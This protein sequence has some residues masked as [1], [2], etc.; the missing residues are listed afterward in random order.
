MSAPPPP[1][2]PPAAP[3]FSDDENLRAAQA[4][5]ER[6]LMRQD[7]TTSEVEALREV[8]Y[9]LRERNLQRIAAVWRDAFS[10]LRSRS[11]NLVLAAD[12]LEHAL[13]SPQ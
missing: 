2:P 11:D 4:L 5:L 9:A 12:H 8:L 1:P 13:R 10:Q 6:E 3:A 7:L